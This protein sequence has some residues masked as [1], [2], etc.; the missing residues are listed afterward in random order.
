[1]SILLN[2]WLAH[3]IA[4]HRIVIEIE[5]RQREL[6]DRQTHLEG[7]ILKVHEQLKTIIDQNDKIVA[8]L[9]EGGLLNGNK[10]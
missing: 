7:M 1:M 8:A 5:Q 3:K 4:N 6:Y 10:R 2:R 9:Y